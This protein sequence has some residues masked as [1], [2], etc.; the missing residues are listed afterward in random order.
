MFFGNPNPI[1]ALRATAEGQPFDLLTDLGTARRRLPLYAAVQEHFVAEGIKERGFLLATFSFQDLLALRA[2][3]MPTALAL[4]LEQFTPDSLQQFR[5]IF[6]VTGPNHIA[7][8][9]DGLEMSSS[10]S[11]PSM[12]E[13]DAAES[14]SAGTDCQGASG[15][16]M[17]L[18]HPTF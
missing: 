16:S 8:T 10:P 15:R 17:R 12:Y 14:S 9:S 5:S 11:S 6:G 2:V 18:A 13:S 3:G 4:G 1:L 7:A